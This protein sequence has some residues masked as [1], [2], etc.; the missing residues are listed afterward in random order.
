MSIAVSVV[1]QTIAIGSVV[2]I[3]V[4]LSGGSGLGISG[5]LA[6]VSMVTIGVGIAG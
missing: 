3:S 2:S 6:V 5:P 1:G 4:S